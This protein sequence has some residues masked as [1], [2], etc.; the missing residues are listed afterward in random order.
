MEGE[1]KRKKVASFK[2]Y[3]EFLKEVCPETSTESRGKQKKERRVGKK[4]DEK[5]GTM[6]QGK[7]GLAPKR[8]RVEQGREGD[9]EIEGGKSGRKKGENR[10]GNR[11][12][13][14]EY[15]H[16]PRNS[17][18]SLEGRNEEGKREE[19]RKEEERGRT[20]KGGKKMEKSKE[21]KEP[22]GA[23]E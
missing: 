14:R 18:I 9:R 21:E 12:D 16:V 22:S 23:F 4:G 10:M 2:K 6:F 11:G 7:R 5:K 19:N 1:E 20:K 17:Q 13:E 3:A 15:N 8:S